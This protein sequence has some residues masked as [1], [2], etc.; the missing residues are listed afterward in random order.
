MSIFREYI[1]KPLTRSSGWSKVRS[2]HLRTHGACACCGRTTKLEVHHIKDFSTYPELELDGDNL[3]T[4]CRNGTQCHLA[5]GHL[6]DWKR[7]NSYVADDA[8]YLLYRYK[9]EKQA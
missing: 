1:A 5:I 2:R 9:T 4:L 3:I 6:G 7:A 8:A